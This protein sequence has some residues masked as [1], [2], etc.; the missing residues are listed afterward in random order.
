[1]RKVRLGVVGIG[2]LGEFHAQKYYRMPGVELIGVVDINRKRA[3]RVAQQYRTK[4]YTNYPEIFDKVEAVSIVVPTQFHYQVAKDFLRQGVD[5]LLEK[6][7]TKTLSQA[8]E[9]IKIAR[10]RNLILQVGHLERFNAAVTAMRQ[11]LTQPL[12]I[13]SQ[14]LS[15]FPQRGIDVDVVLD[16]MI[17]DI[18]IILSIVNSRIKRVEAV[19]VPIL[20]DKI[21]IANAW[22]R[23]GNGC[24][25]NINASRVSSNSNRKIGIF[26]PDSYISLDYHT[27]KLSLY[28]KKAKG[29][30]REPPAIRMEDI[31]LKRNDPLE[32]ELKSFINSVITRHP[33]LVSGMEGKKAL[34]VALR[35]I[36]KM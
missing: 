5:I 33:P 24:V 4:A 29:R 26:Q 6:P 25:A 18:D 7:I 16:L 14:R 19:G 31:R 23:F 27:P 21:D 2:Y 35:I 28:R 36:S 22:I 8:E 34:E 13:E 20:T 1:M 12:F 32:E 9:L 10:E 3:N 17:H 15:P 30:K 11:L